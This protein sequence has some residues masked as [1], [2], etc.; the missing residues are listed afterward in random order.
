MTNYQHAR[1]TVVIAF[2]SH[3]GHIRTRAGDRGPAEYSGHKQTP[4]PSLEDHRDH[5]DP[6]IGRVTLAA[7]GLNP[8]IIATGKPLISFMNPARQLRARRS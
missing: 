4:Q 2:L 1:L 7:P 5:S 6:L 3:I 8:P